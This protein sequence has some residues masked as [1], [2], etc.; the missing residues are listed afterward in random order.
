[1]IPLHF[2]GKGT[3][4]DLFS[5]AQGAMFSQYFS[6]FAS[7]YTLI[8]EKYGTLLAV[9]DSQA[10]LTALRMTLGA[11]FDRILT[12]DNPELLIKTMEREEVNLVV[13]DMNF[14]LGVNSGQ[15]G[16]FWL[17]ALRKRFPT[18]PVVLLTAYAEVNLAVRGLKSGAADF[19]VKPWDN[20][21]LMHKLQDVLQK[22]NSIEKLDTVEA[23][24][25]RHALDVSH[26]N[27]SKAAE[28]L[29]ITRQT[30]Y[31]RLKRK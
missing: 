10:I 2:P 1:M 4:H 3:V 30:L 20:D 15:E 23:E 13:L 14:S 26:G 24:H 25:I 7:S 29:G 17:R 6:I 21:E 12:L 31:N 9:D 16:L 27:M 19:I 5:D 22:H 8:M 18:V 11:M 28:L